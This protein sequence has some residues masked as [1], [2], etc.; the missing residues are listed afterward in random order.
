VERNLLHKIAQ[1]AKLPSEGV[2]FLKSMRKVSVLSE[3]SPRK[4]A[5][6][7]NSMVN[8]SDGRRPNSTYGRLGS[9]RQG[10]CNLPHSTS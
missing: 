10:L 9:A 4:Y 1:F 3:L 7:N 2:N 6:T 8:Q 5:G